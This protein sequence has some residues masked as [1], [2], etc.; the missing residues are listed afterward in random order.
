MPDGRII[1]SMINA[2]A[3]TFEEFAMREPPSACGRRFE[4]ALT[5]LYMREPSRL[6]EF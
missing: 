4:N 2:G 6:K 5:R 3:L 1:Q